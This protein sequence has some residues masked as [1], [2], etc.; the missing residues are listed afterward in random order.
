MPAI[1]QI[2]PT[3]HILADTAAPEA[4]LKELQYGIEE[5]GIPYEQ[6]SKEGC[7]AVALAWEAA[8]ASRLG[9]GVGLD[10]QSLVLHYSKLQ[11]KEPLF[12]L[13][14]RVEKGRVRLLGSNAAR[15][16]KKLPLR[17]LDGR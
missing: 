15:L 17:Y 8:N 13:P 5:E 11:P 4:L 2:K 3:I 12:Q 7:D 9:V 1:Q 6:G 14:A 16:V 10:A